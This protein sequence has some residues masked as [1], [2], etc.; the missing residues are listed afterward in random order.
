[1]HTVLGIGRGMSESDESVSI[2]SSKRNRTVIGI[3][4]YLHWW[5]VQQVVLGFS[6]TDSFCTTPAEHGVDFGELR[7]PRRSNVHINYTYVMVQY[8]VH[9]II[10]VHLYHI[11]Q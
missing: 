3:G 11:I 7:L 2:E 5:C 8:Y 6:V 10:R 4:H 9:I 1:M